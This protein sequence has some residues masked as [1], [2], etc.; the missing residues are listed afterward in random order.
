M[1][2]IRKS[3]A[4]RRCAERGPENT[5]GTHGLPGLL[6]G[7]RGTREISEGSATGTRAPWL[8]FH[9]V[10]HGHIC[11]LVLVLVFEVIAPFLDP[12]GQFLLIQGSFHLTPLSTSPGRVA[13]EVGKVALSLSDPCPSST[14]FLT[15]PSDTLTSALHGQMLFGL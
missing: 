11:C 10:R 2:I 6:W 13:P 1:E 3:V 12:Q 7:V 9:R 8:H 14:L 4:A 5:A 15:L